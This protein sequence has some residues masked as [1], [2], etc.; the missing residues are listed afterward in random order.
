MFRKLL[1]KIFPFVVVNLIRCIMFTCRYR[2]YGFEILRE[3]AK[4]GPCILSIWHNRVALT[5]YICGG[6]MRDLSFT[7]FISNSKDGDLIATVTEYYANAQTLRVPHN[8]R[9]QA[10]RDAI[11]VLK[12]GRIL[13]ITPDGPRGPKYVCKPGTFFAARST[14]A[15]IIPLTWSIDKAWRLNTWDRLIIPKPFAKISILVGEPEEFTCQEDQE[16]IQNT[17][18]KLNAKAESML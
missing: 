2:T 8:A 3:C 15:K 6:L 4:K 9:H 11:K 14:K 17:F 16:R 7:A 18:I 1:L 5:P 10:L 13:I 12:T